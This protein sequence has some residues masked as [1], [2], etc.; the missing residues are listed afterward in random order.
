MTC[1]TATAE[2]VALMLD[3]AAAEGWNP[4]LDDAAAFHAADPEG[5]F[6]AEADGEAVAAISVVNHAKDFAFLGLYLCRPD[7]RG[8]GIGY[9][10][11]KHALDHAGDRTVGLDGVAA[12]QANYARSGFVLTGAT[13]RFE[14][15]LDGAAHGHITPA[16]GEDLDTLAQLDA[17]ANGVDRPRF[18]AAWFAKAPD[19]E[20]VV[21]RGLARIEGFAT[22][23]RCREGVK[24]GPVVADSAEDALALIRAGLG[25]VPAERVI[26]DL[27]AANAK[28][29][30]QLAN[31]GFAVTFETARMY[32]GPAPVP[33]P[34]LQAIATMELG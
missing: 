17:A 16:T 18:A 1:R 29:A 30:A 33:G 11:W 25:A 21:L 20:T 3:W 10:L 2:E 6:M 14:G 8:K 15:S 24:I 32:R 31:L 19:R 27:P 23:R 12:Q 26:I 34:S 28:L 7:F 22:L 5:F 13:R 4:G 9:A